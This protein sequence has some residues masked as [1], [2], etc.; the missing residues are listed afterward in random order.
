VTRIVSGAWGG[1]RLTT[2][3]DARVRPTAERVRE[4]W[5][6]ILGPE[7]HAARV[8]DLFAG[9][10]ALG[11]EALSRGALHATFV[12]L[13]TPSLTALKANVASLKAEAQS[14]VVRHD[15]LRFAAALEPGAFDVALADPPFAGDFA[16]Q[17]VALWQARHFSPVLA[18]E[19]SS[20]VTIPGGE[21]RRWGDVAV[22]FFRAP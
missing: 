15:A 4:A 22:T 10:G 12:E 6:N 5:L 13:H 1:R 19:H 2:P 7:L 8:V 21:T 9:S 16:E 20:K 3:R 17:L 11:L 18:V 14:A